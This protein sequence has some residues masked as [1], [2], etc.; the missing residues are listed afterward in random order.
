MNISTIQTQHSQYNQQQKTT[1]L[2]QGWGPCQNDVRILHLDDSLAQTHQ[3]GTNTNGAA[4]YLITDNHYFVFI[5]LVWTRI[6][7]TTDG[8]HTLFHTIWFSP[9][10]LPLP[11][12]DFLSPLCYFDYEFSTLKQ[13]RIHAHTQTHIHAHTH[14]YNSMVG[15]HPTHSDYLCPWTRDSATV[16]RM[17]ESVI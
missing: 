12:V 17:Y 9:P 10:P 4:C 8:I 2:I 7:L 3:V 13:L 5:L 15:V 6:T 14:I 16:C 11:F 1:H